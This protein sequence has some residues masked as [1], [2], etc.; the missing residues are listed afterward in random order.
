VATAG[1]VSRVVAG[2]IEYGVAAVLLIGVWVGVH[3]IRFLLRPRTF[4]WVQAERIGTVTA[5]LILLT[6]Y[7]AVGWTT[8]GRTLGDQVMGLRVI[9]ASGRRVH[10]LVALGRG[11]FYALFPLGLFWAAVERRNRSVQDLVLRTSVVYDWTHR[12][13]GVDAQV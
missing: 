3:G 6:V 4:E 12:V 8:T 7:L 11:A 13:P 1:I 9:T 10:P 2:A 5:F